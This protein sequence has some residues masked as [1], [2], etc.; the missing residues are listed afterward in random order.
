MMATSDAKEAD[1]RPVH[2]ISLQK[3]AKTKRA[4]DTPRE[5]EEYVHV[6]VGKNTWFTI[7]REQWQRSPVFVRIARES[8]TKEW[9]SE[10]YLRRN[11]KI[12][13]AVVTFLQTSIL[14][15]PLEYSYHDVQAELDFFKLRPRGE[16]AIREWTHDRNEV[17]LSIEQ[18]LDGTPKSCA[19]RLMEEGNKLWENGLWSFDLI[20]Y[21]KT[22]ENV[23][24]AM[25]YF[26]EFLKKNGWR[27]G[28][29]FKEVNAA[30]A[31]LHTRGELSPF[32][33]L[34]PEDRV[35]LER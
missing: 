26:I 13:E 27:V 17:T 28:R 30:H 22:T 6:C 4:A 2:I 21:M 35:Y 23:W 14:V 12:F 11:P 31:R 19:Y 5:E 10:F 34:A 16:E 1:P 20:E 9:W 18:A 29:R 8:A 33:T 32:L 25:T 15:V 3:G 7:T 24:Q